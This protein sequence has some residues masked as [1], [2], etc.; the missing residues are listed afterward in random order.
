ML[1]IDPNYK[2]PPLMDMCKCN[3]CGWSGKV[4]EAIEEMESE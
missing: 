2:R 4:T 3:K 1:E